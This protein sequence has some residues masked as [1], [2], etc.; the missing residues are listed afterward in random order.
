[1]FLLFLLGVFSGSMLV[2]GGVYHGDLSVDVFFQTAPHELPG[3]WSQNLRKL[4]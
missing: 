1:M 3:Q 4:G 2:F